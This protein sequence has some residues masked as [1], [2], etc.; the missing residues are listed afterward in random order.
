[1]LA[2][3]RIVA[4]EPF[5]R[6][7]GDV[8]AVFDT[9]D[10]GNVSYG[11][12]VDGT[13]YFV[14]TAG[15]PADRRDLLDHAT[16]VALLDNAIELARSCRHPCMPELHHVIASDVGPA[17]VYAWL[18]GELV[19]APAARRHDPTTAYQRFRALPVPTIRRCLDQI[20]DVHLRLAA[21]GWIANDFYDGCLIY[22]FAADRL[23]VIDL[24]HYRREPFRNTM[25]RMFGSTRFMAPEEHELGALIDETTTVFTLGRTIQV[26]LSS[27]HEVA[28]RACE[29][30]RTRRFRSVA[31]L[32]AAWAS[33]R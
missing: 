23:G 30:D 2:C 22:D 26:L 20:I 21:A 15:D 3:E 6:S 12:D 25:G 16:R 27:A 7:I 1:L 14:K 31:E 11:V 4:V 29:L 9:Q 5:L 32:A 18:P 13:R 28:A 17:L 33:S 8:F 24:D 10:S 19:N